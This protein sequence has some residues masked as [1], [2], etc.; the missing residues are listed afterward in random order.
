MMVYNSIS[1]LPL[2]DSEADQNHRKDYAFGQVYPLIVYRNNILPFQAVLSAG[3]S[4]NFVRV[5]N[6]KTRA[7]VDVTQ[8]MLSNGLK[9]TA[10]PEQG[11]SII[12]YPGILPVQG[13]QHEGRYFLALSVEGLGILFSEVF[14]VTNRI[15]D[16]LLIE[17]QATYNLE[18]NRG[19]VDF[20]DGFRFQCY[21]G[22]QIG[23]PEYEFE[24]EATERLGYSFI[25]SQVSKK[26]YK[27]T[28]LAPE[29]LC[30][31]LRIVR[32]CDKRRITSKGK[33]YWATAFSIE[34]EWEDQ[35]DLASVETSLETNTVIANI[36]GYISEHDKP[37]PDDPDKYSLW[38]DADLYSTSELWFD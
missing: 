31:A 34:P 2:Y 24:E 21:L 29:F 19:F 4:I 13:I 33:S 5:Y 23:K 26:V 30:D 28:F 6:F 27:F 17:Y 18:L 15:E 11:F 22:T 3:T 10:Y 32:L 12:K 25:E 35:G 14:T 1:P 8:S 9:V 16:F 38:V 36:G 20:S 7:F 37:G